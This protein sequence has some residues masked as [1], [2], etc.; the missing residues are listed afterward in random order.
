MAGRTW[1]REGIHKLSVP[2]IFCNLSLHK[3]D[4]GAFFFSGRHLHTIQSII[5][6]NFF[7]WLLKLVKIDFFNWR[8]KPTKVK[9]FC[10][11]CC[12]SIFFLAFISNFVSQSFSVHKLCGKLKI[13]HTVRKRAGCCGL[14]FHG[15]AHLIGITL[16]RLFALDRVVWEKW[17]WNYETLKLWN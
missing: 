17:L 16:L 14:A 6:T 9:C 13:P 5:L 2:G 7:L 12:S 8:Q 1:R 15:L 10:I 4:I 3:C 11:D